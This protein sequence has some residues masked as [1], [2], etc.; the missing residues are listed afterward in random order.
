MIFKDW[1]AHT[2]EELYKNIVFY[3]LGVNVNIGRHTRHG[4]ERSH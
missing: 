3:I 2:Y 1:R 4:W